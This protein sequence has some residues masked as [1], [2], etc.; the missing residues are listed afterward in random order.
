MYLNLTVK[1]PE[2]LSGI[3]N[4]NYLKFFLT[5]RLR[6]F[7]NYEESTETYWLYG[8]NRMGLYPGKT[9]QRRCNQR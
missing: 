9:L 8:S 2:Q 7:T 3:P 4:G 5:Q 6:M 1:I